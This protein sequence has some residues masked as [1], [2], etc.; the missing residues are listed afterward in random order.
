MIKNTIISLAV[1]LLL[2]ACSGD[3]STDTT[4]ETNTTTQKTVVINGHTLPPVPDKILNDSTLLGIDSNDNG[5][6][7]DVEI[8]IYETYQ[9]KHP[10]HIDIAMQAGRAWQKV[11]EDP[12]RAIEI[13]PIISAASSC[14]A[15]YKVCIKQDN[16]LYIKREDEII[17]SFFVEEL[18]FNTDN[19]NQA[20]LTYDKLLSG[21]SYT[22]PWCSE[23]EQLCD[24]NTTKY[25]E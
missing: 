22:I 6:R 21:G 4:A 24:F 8:W 23:K 20:F 10:I 5:V 9:D 11:L 13:R 1:I 7:D 18:F 3:D 12:S 17:N 2:S 16:P 15:Y 25:E 19:R 14:E